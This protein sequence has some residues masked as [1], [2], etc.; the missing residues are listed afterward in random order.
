MTIGHVVHEH[1]MSIVDPTFGPRLAAA[2]ANARAKGLW[3]GTYAAQNE[4]EYWAEATQ[5]WFDTNRVN[6]NEHGPIDTRAKLLPY[7]P[8]I[9]RLL[10][11]V[12]G[13]RPWRYVRPSQRPASERSHLAGFDV[14]KAGRFV[15]PAQPSVSPPGGGATTV[16]FVNSRR[17]DVAIDWLD[18]TGQRRRYWLLR[19]GQRAVQPTYVGHVW[20]FSEGA[21]TLGTVSAGANGQVVDIR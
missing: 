6:D 4:M 10:E 7:D 5:S 11:E 19:A 1:A 16:T 9:A 21:N 17:A 3:S 12:Y 14:A 13:N 15:W 20:V 2:Y 18:G 8:T